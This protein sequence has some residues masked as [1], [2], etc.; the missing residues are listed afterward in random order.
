M[1]RNIPY[2]TLYSPVGGLMSSISFS[3]PTTIIKIPLAL[4]T[5]LRM[6]F[7]PHINLKPARTS[8]FVISDRLVMGELSL[9]GTAELKGQ[10]I[11]L[12][13]N[14]S[15]P[16]FTTTWFFPH[17]RLWRVQALPQCSG[18]MMSHE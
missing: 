11:N 1:A 3:G 9:K 2:C 10:R 6:F 13:L 8:S 18:M 17:L 14:G 4:H 12:L 7:R 5:S 15:A 16:L